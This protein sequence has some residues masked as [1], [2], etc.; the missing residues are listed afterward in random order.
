MKKFDHFVEIATE[1][2]E[3]NIVFANGGY[4][5][6]VHHDLA[7]IFTQLMV[8]LGLY[9]VLPIMTGAAGSVLG[10]LISS[11]GGNRVRLGV[12]R[13]NRHVKGEGHFIDN[14]VITTDELVEII[15]EHSSDD[16]LLVNSPIDESK[17]FEAE[18]AL[19]QFLTSNGWPIRIAETSAK[20]IISKILE[21]SH[22]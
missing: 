16:A 17:A 6:N 5:D 21:L 22:Q 14:N 1:V 19:T 4:G 18:N 9:I 20:E 8:Y 12:V 11:R 15:K 7:A 10:N 3:P 2:L 13:G